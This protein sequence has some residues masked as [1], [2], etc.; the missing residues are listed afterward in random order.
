VSLRIAVT[1]ALALGLLSAPAAEAHRRPAP[2]PEAPE[3]VLSV[4]VVSDPPP[5]L[6]A[7]PTF[8]L[9]PWLAVAAVGATVGLGALGRSRDARRWAL[10]LLFAS[11]TAEL[12][13]HGVHHIQD[14]RGAV[15]CYA[16]SLGQH[17]SAASPPAPDLD[18]PARVWVALLVPPLEPAAA[19]ASR[20][21]DRGRAP[22]VRSA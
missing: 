5:K 4:P 22:P 16:L 9:S 11:F 10:V 15:D 12:A 7:A 8:H 2:I 3:P 19:S 6:S 18:G 13:V 20:A 17:L 14:P 1:L 21:P